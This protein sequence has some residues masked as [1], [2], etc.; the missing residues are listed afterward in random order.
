MKSLI[1]IVVL[2]TTIMLF[3]GCVKTPP[4]EFK[5]LPKT[6]SFVINELQNTDYPSF[7]IGEGN[8]YSC[9]YGIHYMTDDEFAYPRI[10]V[11]EKLLLKNM[12]SIKSSKIKLKQFDIYINRR[13]VSLRTMSYGIAGISPLAH[14]IIYGASQKNRY[15]VMKDDFLIDSIPQT[16]PLKTEE[17]AV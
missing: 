8:I 10:E 12:P 5:E 13:L 15:G 7:I 14:G 6:E 9:R 4:V 11:F 3:S 17:D 2:I 1:Q 16:Y